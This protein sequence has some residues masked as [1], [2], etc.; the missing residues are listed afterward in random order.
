MHIQFTI[1]SLGLVV[2][3][4]PAVAHAAFADPE[5][6]VTENGQLAH[7]LTFKDVQ[8]GFAGFTGQSYRID[9]DGTWSITRVFNR[10]KFKPTKTGK[11]TPDQLKTL[12]A[13][14]KK[15][16]LLQLPKESGSQAQANPHVMT[17]TFGKKKSAIAVGAGLEDPKK[18]PNDKSYD[19]ARRAFAIRETIRSLIDSKRKQD[20]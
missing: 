8:G 11:L 13:S 1:L 14:L 18:L 7:A 10:R 3:G 2:A 17:I 9:P 15:N 12:V 6:I 16:G 5:T 20:R 19:A 4:S